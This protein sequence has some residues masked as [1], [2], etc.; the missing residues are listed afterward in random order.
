MRLPRVR[1]TI[2][3]W[4]IVVVVSALVLTPFAWVSPGARWPLLI[5]CLTFALFFLV[6]ASP[7][8][9][10]LRHHNV[11]SSAVVKS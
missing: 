7:F 8:L 4:L 5:F 9:T 1:F 11:A 2:R 10:H 3:Q 6:A